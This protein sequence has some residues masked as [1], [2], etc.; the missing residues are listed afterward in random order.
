MPYDVLEIQVGGESFAMEIQ[1]GGVSN[2]FGNPER[3]GG[4]VKTCSSVVGGGGF[5]K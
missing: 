1:G 5:R 3:R 2:A 4:G